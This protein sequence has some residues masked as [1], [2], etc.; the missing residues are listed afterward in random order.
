MAKTNKPLTNNQKEDALL[1]K[2]YKE[3]FEK[4]KIG[5]V[6]LDKNEVVINMKSAT[7]SDYN[8]ALIK[9]K[10]KT[11]SQNTFTLENGKKN[12]KIVAYCSTNYFDMD[13]PQKG[14]VQGKYIE[15]LKK[16]I[17]TEDSETKTIVLFGGDLLGT[18]WT[19]NYLKKADIEENNVNLYWGLNK[20]KQRLIAD[21]KI[22][23][24]LGADV[25]LMQGNQEQVIMRETG[26]DILKEIVEELNDSKVKYIDEGTTVVCNLIYRSGKKVYNNSVAFQTIMRR[27]PQNINADFMAAQKSNGSVIADA[28]FVFNGNTSGKFGK[29]IYHVSGQSMFKKTIKGDR[30]EYAPKNYNVFTIYPEDNHCLTVVEGSQE[31]LYSDNLALENKIHEQKKTRKILGEIAKQKYDEQIDRLV[32]D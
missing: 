1:Q 8:N 13:N 22:A 19:L 18:Q 12:L 29:N 32:H 17:R 6:N 7:M 15:A 5:K 25:Y 31:N 20:R 9:K 27:K 10:V 26:R 16:D 30:P 11:L 23:L 28:V 14:R 2:Y 21:I 4:E 24:T 3:N